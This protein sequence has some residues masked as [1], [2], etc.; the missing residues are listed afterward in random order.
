LLPFDLLSPSKYKELREK[1]GVFDCLKEARKWAA[2]AMVLSYAVDVDM[3]IENTKF[4]F[5]QTNSTRNYDCSNSF[6]ILIFRTY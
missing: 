4:R 5:V 1:I 3:E 6:S 2:P